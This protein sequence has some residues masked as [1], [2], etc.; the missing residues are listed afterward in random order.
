ML[1]GYAEFKNIQI[2]DLGK[3]F[4]LENF[5]QGEKTTVIAQF[6]A[7]IADTPIL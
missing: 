7:L 2:L 4:D 1:F 3:L 5:I 6:M